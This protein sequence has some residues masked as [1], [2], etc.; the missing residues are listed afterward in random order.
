MSRP[1]FLNKVREDWDEDDHR[2]ERDLLK[3]RAAAHGHFLTAVGLDSK[4]EWWCLTCLRSVPEELVTDVLGWVTHPPEEDGR[5]FQEAVAF[6]PSDRPELRSPGQLGRV[7]NKRIVTGYECL[8]C[9]VDSR[10]DGE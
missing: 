5:C 7:V 9:G 4:L 1:P 3:L 8:C 6:R 2:L 10:G